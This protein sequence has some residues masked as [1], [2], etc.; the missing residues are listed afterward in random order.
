MAMVSRIAE[1][2]GW[3]GIVVYADLNNNGALDDGEPHT[4]TM[5]EILETDFDEGGLYWLDG[6]EPGTYIIREVV[7]DDLMQTFPGPAVCVHI[8]AILV[9][10]DDVEGLTTTTSQIRRLNNAN[11]GAMGICDLYVSCT[12]PNLPRSIN[13]ACW[14][15]T[16]SIRRL[17]LAL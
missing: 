9:S 6:L 7:P 16:R 5:E 2:W 1:S 15:V 4:V 14:H 8:L 3:G 17:G 11:H 13:L 12:K 10:L